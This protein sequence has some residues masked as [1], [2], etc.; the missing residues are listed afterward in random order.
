M[1]IMKQLLK[2][3][4]SFCLLLLVISHGI[5]QF[6]M[7][8]LFR[9]DFRAEAARLIR[10]GVPEPGRA[11]FCFDKKEFENEKTPVEWKGDDEF[12]FEGK[13]FDVI[14]TEFKGDSVYFYCLYDEDDTILFSVL[15][16]M[17]EDDRDDP[18]ET[19]G[20]GISL[21]NY[22]VCGNFDYNLDSP[23]S[24]EA[25]CI[26]PGINLLEGEYVINIPPPRTAA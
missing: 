17:I 14:R 16:S 5:I 7:F 21:S 9:A 19:D 12:R 3:L 18:E 15:D 2:N 24:E 4:T 8:E 6:G 20:L 10:A 25:Y 13:L 1:Y 11:V 26:N 22:Y 23:G